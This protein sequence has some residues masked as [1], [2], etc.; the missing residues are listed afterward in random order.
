MGQSLGA[1]I[2]WGYDLG[3]DPFDPGYL[4]YSDEDPVYPDWWEDGGHEDA[5]AK[6]KGW[7]EIEL[8][9]YPPH[10]QPPEFRGTWLDWDAERR[11]MLD[12][13]EKT[14]AYQEWSANRD[15]RRRIVDACPVE[16]ASY[17]VPAYWSHHIVVVKASIHRQLDACAMITPAML[18]SGGYTATWETELAEYLELMGIPAP[19]N[20][21][22]GWLLAL[23]YG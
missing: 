13:Y 8:V 3:E 20:Q 23:D 1:L 5:Y 17:G 22:P 6:L 19:K 9:G 2:G 16:I 4:D 10:H 11:R 7:R 14:S 12:E 18:D 21:A 15:E